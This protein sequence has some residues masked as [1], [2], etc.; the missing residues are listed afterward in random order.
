[1]LVYAPGAV[2]A[3]DSIRVLITQIGFVKTAVKIPDN[4]DA[5]K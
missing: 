3:V 4:P 5:I 2:L 1:M